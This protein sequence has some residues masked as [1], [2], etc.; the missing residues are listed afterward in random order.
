[1]SLLGETLKV[2]RE[3]HGLGQEQ[4]AARLGVTQQTISRWE[5]GL[6]VPRP[7]RVVQLAELL[8]VDARWLHKV[9]GYL[10]DAE[11]SQ[12]SEPWQEIYHRVA[13]LTHTEL[14]LLMDRVWEELRSREGLNPPGT[15]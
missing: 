7:S 14:M 10:P 9:A 8:E 11:R 12:A 2:R 6:A 5:K 13:E 1:M 15:K 4:V 3:E